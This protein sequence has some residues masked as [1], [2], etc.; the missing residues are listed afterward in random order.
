MNTNRSL[1][2]VIKENIKDGELSDTF[3]LPREDDDDPNK[4][5]WADGAMD[6]ISI[7]HMG[8]PEITD[9]QM[10][11]VS[12]A[13]SMLDD[14]EHVM[15][16]M[17]DFFAEI[18]PL[19]GIDAI[20]KFIFD[21]INTLD[22]RAVYMLAVD[23]LFSC[24]IDIV[25]FGMI[26]I[27]LF[28]EPDESLKDII[29]TLGLSDEFTIFAVFDMMSWSDGNN[30][31]FELARKVHGWGRIHAVERLEPETQEIKDWLLAEGINNEVVPDYSAL[32][33]YQ[34][35]DI[36]TL[37][38][39]NITDEQLEQI[40]QLLISMFDEGPVNCISALPENE[41]NTMLRDF[42]TQVNKH[43]LSLDICRI[44]L[45]ISRD[46]RFQNFASEC[47]EI[48][49]SNECKEL[50][51]IELKSG[52]AI[53]LAKAV[54]IPYKEKIFEFMKNDFENGY[55]LCNHLIDDEQYREQV[56]DLFRK[57]LPVDSM[58]GEPTK[59]SGYYD[60]Y[61][62]YNKLTFLIQYLDK[63][64]MCG[65]DLVI[66]ALNMPTV[67]CRNQ[68]ITT[69]SLWCKE[70]NCTLSEL[71]DDILK[72]VQHMKSIEVDERVINRIEKNGF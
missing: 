55:R 46:E 53:E 13:F 38:K 64:P 67:Q 29:R 71:S 22:H 23:C 60:L 70:K 32:E 11:I 14:N 69:I 4:L 44:I 5:R 72:A 19:S 28:H 25:K 41:A 68:A 31:I 17:K 36:A 59:E 21:H 10:D 35:A 30:E 33:V 18:T 6:G 52:N 24:D 2:E 58:V 7:Y 20:Q 3:S 54:N 48:L 12:D 65:S 39:K 15:A 66:S 56:I 43:T 42:I 9:S 51:E 57:S 34:K 8:R 61:S 40:A 16:R 47:S 27:E 62:D 50:I 45:T 1:L 49:N 26:L 63:Y 37:L